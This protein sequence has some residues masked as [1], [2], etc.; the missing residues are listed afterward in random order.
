MNENIEMFNNDYNVRYENDANSSTS[1]REV[2]AVDVSNFSSLST[3]LNSSATDG[4]IHVRILQSFALTA[5]LNPKRNATTIEGIGPDIVLTR[6]D[7]FTGDLFYLSSPHANDI[8][9]KNITIDGN[10][11]THKNKNTGAIIKS[12]Y[13]PEIRLEDGAVL[14]NNYNSGNGGAI[15]NTVGDTL[16]TMKGRSM[17]INNISGGDGGAICH[18]A[19]GERLTLTMEGD[20]K[21]SGNIAVNG[22]AIWSRGY[23]T[24]TLSAQAAITD[25]TA[26]AKG[27]AIYCTALAAYKATFTININGFASISGNRAN[28]GGVLYSDSSNINS[29]TIN[30]FGNA[31]MCLNTALQGGAIY[32][33]N[34]VTFN[35]S[36]SA[37]LCK[38]TATSHGGG[39]YATNGTINIKGD[40]IVADNESLTGQGGA[41]YM[42]SPAT[43]RI[44]ERA[45]LIN[46]AALKGDGGAIGVPQGSL[47]RLYV[48]SA[49]VVFENNIAKDARE[50]DSSFANTYNNNIKT[51]HFSYG[52]SNGYN[53][54][55]IMNILGLLTPMYYI[56]IY[57]YGKNGEPVVLPYFPDRAFPELPTPTRP[58]A[59]FDD[60]YI[61]EELETPLDK[62]VPLTKDTHLYPK[63]ICNDGYRPNDDD[64]ACVK[65]TGGGGSG[66]GGGGGSGSGSNGGIPVISLENIELG[67]ALRNVIASIALQEASIAG[68]LNSESEKIDHVIADEESNTDDLLRVNESANS[69]VK[70]VARLEAILVDKLR[71][72][73]K[74]MPKS[75]DCDACASCPPVTDE[76]PETEQPPETEV[77]EGEGEPEGSRVP[78]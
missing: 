41:I 55:D 57:I 58:H 38:N 53:N 19:S 43:V 4:T 48:D 46:N 25:N 1:E 72:S 17:I 24:I 26:S 40:S 54:F 18:T 6:G 56:Y 39:I 78:V 2:R 45:K 3:Q 74:H 69:F 22:G 20:S 23:S 27:G 37:Q 71:M 13:M 64:T 30:L 28:F 9:F 36:G 21:I 50:M 68:L 33:A 70:T 5:Q 32:I 8:T 51:E 44:S 14:Q 12:T 7:T 65:D 16:I 60:W 52:L 75:C 66:G 73:L 10:T 61:D 59:T 29:S 35:V 31:A 11:N 49:D 47:G 67:V 15:V 77:P 42:D 76:P 34:S 63:F 62:N